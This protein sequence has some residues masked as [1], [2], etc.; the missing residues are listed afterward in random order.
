MYSNGDGVQKSEVIAR[1]W[2]KKSAS[3]NLAVAQYAL[4]EMYE[5]GL[6]GPIDMNAAKQ[7]YKKSSENGL[8]WGKDKLEELS[9]F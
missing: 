1:E 9:K 3:Q 2:M 6:G 8:S 4:A 7:W 5:T